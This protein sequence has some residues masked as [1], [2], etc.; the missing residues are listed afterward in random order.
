MIEND[1]LFKRLIEEIEDYAIL[2][3]SNKGDALN[4]NSGARKMTGYLAEEAIGKKFGFFYSKQNQDAK[5]PEKL[6]KMEIGRAHV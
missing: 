5:L 3:F 4:W 6:L 2:L 1:V